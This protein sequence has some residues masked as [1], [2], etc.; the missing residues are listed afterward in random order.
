[1]FDGKI[2]PLER[3]ATMAAPR[4]DVHEKWQ[5]GLG[6]WLVPE[7]RLSRSKA[8]M[9]VCPFALFTT[10]TDT[11]CTV[12]SNWTDGAWP[13]VVSLVDRLFR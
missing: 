10:G 4:S 13:L 12:V 3:V 5:Y 9:R 6:L 11:T 8:A 7:R 1:M 2:V